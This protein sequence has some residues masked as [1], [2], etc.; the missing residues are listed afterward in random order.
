MAWVD[1]PSTDSDIDSPE[2]EDIF[3]SLANNDV[4]LRIAPVGFAL[5]ETQAT[6]TGYVTLA[7]VYVELP[8]VASSAIQRKLVFRCELKATAG[9]TMTLKITDNAAAVDSTEASSTSTS[10]ED[11]E[12]TLNFAEGLKGTKRQIDIKGKY[13]TNSPGF[14]QI[15]NAITSELHF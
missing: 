12:V 3:Q 9:G 13:T 7:T 2:D 8:D 15:V 6:S 4:A 5:A 1:I 14:V 10:Y 11:K